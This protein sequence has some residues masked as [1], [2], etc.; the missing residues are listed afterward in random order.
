MPDAKWEFELPVCDVLEDWVDWKRWRVSLE[1]RAA[2][3]VRGAARAMDLEPNMIEVLKR[4]L[5]GFFQVL[6]VTLA[7]A[8]AERVVKEVVG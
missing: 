5:C 2:W 3:A 4:S 1:A 8:R 7:G 6:G